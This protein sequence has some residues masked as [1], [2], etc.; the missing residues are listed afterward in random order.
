MMLQVAPE[1]L[2]MLCPVECLRMHCA[3]ALSG[4]DGTSGLAMP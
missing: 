2:A 4:A 1:G 3:K